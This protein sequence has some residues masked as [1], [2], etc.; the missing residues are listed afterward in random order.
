MNEIL[1]ALVPI[2][3]FAC[4]TAVAL[5][6][7]W[8]RHRER[9]ASLPAGPGAEHVAAL[10]ARLARIEHAVEAVGV[11]VERVSEGQR[12]VTRL[13]ADRA[14]AAL[15]EPAPRRVVVTPH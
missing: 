13:L 7:G 10:E 15:Q 2:V 4:P 6:F 11:E 5:A 12:F 9:M 8:F 3:V 14:P 1:H